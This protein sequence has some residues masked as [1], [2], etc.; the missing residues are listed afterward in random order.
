[1]TV[2]NVL[3]IPTQVFRDLG[4]FQGF[5]AKPEK[6]NLSVA[7]LLQC[8]ELQYMPRPAAEENPEF[9]Q[10]IPYVVF[11]SG[12]GESTQIY[13][14]ARSSKSGEARLH[15]KRSIGI[16]GHISAEDG[17]VSKSYAVG[18][19]REM[20]EELGTDAMRHVP[21]D[22]L[23]SVYGILNDD[24]DDVGKV[25]LGVVHR[26][27]LEVPASDFKPESTMLD[28]KFTPLRQLF[29]EMDQ[30][31]NWSQLILRHMLGD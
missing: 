23:S 16:G 27:Q 4:Y 13:N 10:L 31:E 30:F 22:Y 14:Y 21:L 3:V 24:S 29:Q 19:L 8:Q 26:I 12:R 6:E 1:M 9:K 28:P 17:H 20:A 2:E 15:A 7:R 5:K 25:H 18:M 11:V